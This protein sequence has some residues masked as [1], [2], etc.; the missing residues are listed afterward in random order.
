MKKARIRPN[1][2]TTSSVPEP[3]VV[4]EEE[5]TVGATHDE[6]PAPPVPFQYQQEE[7]TQET[8]LSQMLS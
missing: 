1:T 4:D 7:W 8:M 5:P 2:A 3:Y 6:E